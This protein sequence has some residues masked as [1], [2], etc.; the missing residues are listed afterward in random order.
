MLRSCGLEAAR[1]S[2][3]VYKRRRLV[4]LGCAVLF[5][6]V[7]V[8]I[9]QGGSS[10]SEPAVES[11][12]PQTAPISTPAPAVDDEPRKRKKDDDATSGGSSTPGATPAPSAPATPAPS[13]PAT[14][15][16][17]TPA[18]PPATPTE[19]GTDPDTGGATPPSSGGGG[20]TG[21]TAP[22]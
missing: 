10:D 6:T 20:S 21:G 11:F 14:P 8:A 2:Q 22:E 15:A 16:P 7:V 3:A 9:A 5:L 13:T 12:D 17:S 19:P 18:T 4:A 1:E